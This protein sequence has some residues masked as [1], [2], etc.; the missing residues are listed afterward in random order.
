MGVDGSS[1]KW[2]GDERSRE[3]QLIRVNA[4]YFASTIIGRRAGL[5]R[6]IRQRERGNAYDTVRR[7]AVLLRERGL[8]I[9]VHG[10]GTYVA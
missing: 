10:R 4:G 3:P 1:D 2:A 9:T 8:I 5:V 6:D 7:A